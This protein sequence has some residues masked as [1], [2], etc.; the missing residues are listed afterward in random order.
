MRRYRHPLTPCYK[1]LALGRLGRGTME[2]VWPPVQCTFFIASIITKGTAN[3]PS[4]GVLNADI[5][6]SGYSRHVPIG[7]RGKRAAVI[8]AGGQIAAGHI[9]Q[10]PYEHSTDRVCGE[11]FCYNCRSC[12]SVSRRYG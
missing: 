1:A 9:R 11:P 4:V 7:G 3:C 12:A 6:V 5:P 8:H 2:A 10:H